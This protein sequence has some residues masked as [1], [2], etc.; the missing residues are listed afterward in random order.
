MLSSVNL[1]DEWSPKRSVDQEVDPP[2]RWSVVVEWSSQGIEG[3]L[4]HEPSRSASAQV[5]LDPTGHELPFMAG[6]QLDF[7]VRFE[8]GAM[9]A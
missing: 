7:S 4:R 9:Q 1:H 6:S 8:F 5:L 3:S 2:S